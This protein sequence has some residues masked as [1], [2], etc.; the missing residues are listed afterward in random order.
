MEEKLR[1]LI[2][3]DSSQH[4]GRLA[5]YLSSKEE[6]GLCETAQNGAQVLSMLREKTFDILVTDVVLQQVDGFG[7]LE[8]MRSMINAPKVIFLSSLSQDDVIRRVCELGA[9]YYLIKPFDNE[10]L[11]QRILDSV[12]VSYNNEK[13]TYQ[14]SAVQT[15]HSTPQKSLDERVA[16]IFLAVGIPAHIK[17]YH[18]LREAVKLV[19]KD[20]SIINS[21]TK[22]LYP[23]VAEIFSTSP[24]KVE[25]AIR[26]AIEV[27][28]SRGKIENVNGIFGYTIYN[29]HEKPT[30]GEFIALVADKLLMDDLTRSEQ[31]SSG[32][33]AL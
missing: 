15:P 6:V 9:Y 16:N 30:N 24:S 31:L 14:H 22:Q 33:I 11:Y 29:S 17:G 8:Q 32:S 7:I 27:A 10:N 1:I 2:A 21:I 23:G 20:R 13:E 12:R 19:Y 5:D 18:F 28:W 3:D 4:R 26:H 25:R